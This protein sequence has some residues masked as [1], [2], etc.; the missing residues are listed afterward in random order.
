MDNI[1]ELCARLA[2]EK[3]NLNQHT[4]RIAR[5]EAEINEAMQRTQEY[6]SDQPAGQSIVRLL[7]LA[8]NELAMADSTFYA[9][10]GEITT[11]VAELQK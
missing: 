10:G 3:N 9:F 2:A 6:F 1:E 11:Y 8:L 4:S 5:M 7:S